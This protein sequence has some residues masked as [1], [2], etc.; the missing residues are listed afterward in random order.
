MRFVRAKVI[1]V[2]RDRI[3]AGGTYLVM[4]YY[5]GYMQAL[6]DAYAGCGGLQ[7]EHVVRGV[8]VRRVAEVVGVSG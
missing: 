6:R 2:V 4:L 1:S 7:G 8:D 3:L 5:D